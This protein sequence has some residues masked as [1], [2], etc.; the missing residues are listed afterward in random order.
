MFINREIN[1]FFARRMFG[2][3]VL[4]VYGP[5]QSGKTT[6]IEH[7]LDISGLASETVTFNGDETA[8]R[9]LLADISPERLKLLIGGKKVVFIDEAQ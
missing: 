6:A 8:D 5:R 9:Q 7:Y 3:K 2:G 1:E 4:V